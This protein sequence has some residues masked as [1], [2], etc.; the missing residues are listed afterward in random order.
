MGVDEGYLFCDPLYWAGLVQIMKDEAN[1]VF[2][3]LQDTF[4]GLR[5]MYMGITRNENWYEETK[6]PCNMF[7]W[8]VQL[9]LKIKV[10]P[11]TGLVNEDIHIRRD[12]V[13]LT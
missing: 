5:I 7:E 12:G 8:Y 6:L 11:I 9:E 13:H 10:T 1:V 3:R 4:K 2:E